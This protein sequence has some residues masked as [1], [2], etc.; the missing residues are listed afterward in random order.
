MTSRLPPDAFPE[1]PASTE[2]VSVTVPKDIARIIG[3]LLLTGAT[4][5][6]SKDHLSEPQVLH[7]LA[8]HT[9]LSWFALG[10]YPPGSIDRA[11]VPFFVALD[12]PPEILAQVCEIGATLDRARARAGG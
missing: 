4:A 9:Q 10:L 5:V 1:P 8:T 12:A 11:L 2:F 3:T 6:V 7:A